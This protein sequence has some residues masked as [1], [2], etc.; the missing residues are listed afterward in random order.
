MEKINLQSK[1]NALNGTAEKYWFEN[2]HI[3][4]KRTLFHRVYIPLKPFNSG[5]DYESQPVET[6]IEMEWM[7][8]NLADPNNLDN[9]SLTST[10]EDETEVSIYLGSAHNPCD[11]LK[12]N[13]NKTV[14][15]S[16]KVRCELLVDF[17]YERVA[18][19]ET[20]TFETTVEF[21][22]IEKE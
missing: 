4:L 10:P 20:F 13:W 1:T 18:S 21:N 12:M 6:K 9:L 8:L 17:E 7:N 11:I 22:P 15:N 5:L 19:N 2:K 16:Y 3:G 14:D